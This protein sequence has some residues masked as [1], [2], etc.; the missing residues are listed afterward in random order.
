MFTQVFAERYVDCNPDQVKNFKNHET[1]LLLAFAIIMLNTD[2]HNASIKQERKMK[3]E[4]FI[5][6]LRGNSKKF[7]SPRSKDDAI[8]LTQMIK[9]CRL[10]NKDGIFCFYGKMW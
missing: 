4:D 8:F 1:V 2:L 7:S 5:K 6:N 10:I 9:S 3:L